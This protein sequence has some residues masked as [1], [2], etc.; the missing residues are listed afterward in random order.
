M[1]KRNKNDSNSLSI[2]PQSKIEAQIFRKHQRLVNAETKFDSST[3]IRNP[4]DIGSKRNIKTSSDL[5]S[6]PLLSR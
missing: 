4:S 3:S 2:R 1:G 5:G 6:M